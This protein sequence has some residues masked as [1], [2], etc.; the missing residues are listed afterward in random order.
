MRIC[1][2]CLAAI[3][4]AV[5]PCYAQ[6]TMQMPSMP[7]MPTVSTSD[8]EI[9]MP[10]MPTITTSTSSAFKGKFYSPDMPG[11]SNSTAEDSKN[12]ASTTSTTNSAVLT[13]GTSATDL[14]SSFINSN[15]ILSA[16]D[17]SNLYDSGVFSDIS[18]IS[19]L[20]SVL[21]KNS[22]LTENSKTTET[23][24]KQI[25]T[26]LE[27]LKNEQKNSGDAEK[28]NLELQKTDAQTFKQRKPSILRFKINGYNILD[29]LSTV[30]FSE[31][32]A[33][34]SFLLTAD[35]KYFTNQK[36]RTET[37]YIL[38]K[39]VRTSGSNTNYTVQPDI[40]Q[41]SKN[42]NSFVYKL[43]QQKNLTAEKLGNLVVLK[44]SGD[45]KIDILLDIDK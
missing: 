26:T 17:I 39:A 41:D 4:T 15:S 23:M 13:D 5:L 40:V 21:T 12:T 45:L 36:A 42:E 25:L 9:T 14:I 20:S 37:F 2:F 32:E 7:E 3:F 29:S 8:T 44:N 34:G 1:K 33:D 10:E 6:S 43:C 27:E 30:F 22:A 38:F 16:S 31:P 24:L 18:S 19:D 28:E 35:R 11:K